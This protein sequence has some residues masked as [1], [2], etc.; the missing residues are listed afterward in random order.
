MLFLLTGI[1]AFVQTDTLTAEQAKTMVNKE[2]IVKENVAGTRLLDK[3]G[4]R[5]LHYNEVWCHPTLKYCLISFNKK[6]LEMNAFRGLKT[7]FAVVL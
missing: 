6:N 4:N 2:V 5:T 7:T 3:D 1:N